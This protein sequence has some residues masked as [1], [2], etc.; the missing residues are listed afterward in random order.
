M[1]GTHALLKRLLLFSAA[2][3]PERVHVLLHEIIGEISGYEGVVAAVH[4][5][6]RHMLS[7]PTYESSGND[8]PPAAAL[9]VPARASSLLSPCEFPPSEYFASLAHPMLAAPGATA[10]KMPGLPLSSIRLSEPQTFEDLRFEKAAPEPL[11]QYELH[12]V[13]ERDGWLRGACVHIELRMLDSI[14]SEPDV[15]S[16]VAPSHWPNVLLLLESEVHVE[17]G[18][19]IIIRTHA[20]LAGKQ[21]RYEF[22]FFLEE[23]SPLL[24]A[25]M[26]AESTSNELLPGHRLVGMVRYPD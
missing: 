20:E 2:A 21:P 22:H 25:N 14:K 12:F 24:D 17:H 4:D 18:Q 3:L 8:A 11:Q 23:T 6:R 9:S 19:K 5:A 15:S 1:N 10:L 26:T 16:A 7:A 13:A